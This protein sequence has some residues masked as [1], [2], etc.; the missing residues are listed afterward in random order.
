MTVGANGQINSFD[1]AANFPDTD[2]PVRAAKKRF[3]LSGLGTH[4]LLRTR[5]FFVAL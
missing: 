2:L 4:L 3:C 1:G 5:N